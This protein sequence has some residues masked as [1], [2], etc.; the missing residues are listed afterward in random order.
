MIKDAFEDYKR[1]KND[2][3]ENNMITQV[4]TGSRDEL[5]E[6]KWKDVKVGQVIKIFKGG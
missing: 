6:T 5:K 3:L 4:A 2:A 1:S